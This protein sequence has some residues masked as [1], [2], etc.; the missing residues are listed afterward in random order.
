MNKSVAVLLTSCGECHTMMQR[1]PH[2]AAANAMQLRGE[3]HTMLWRTP[4]M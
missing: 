1:M 4:H 3:R 2:D